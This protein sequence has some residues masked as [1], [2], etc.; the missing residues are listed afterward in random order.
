LVA[1]LDFSAAFHFAAAA[2]AAAA[3]HTEHSVEQVET[4]A[5][6]TQAEAKY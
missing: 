5:L 6:S 2:L 1:A 4:E 3:I